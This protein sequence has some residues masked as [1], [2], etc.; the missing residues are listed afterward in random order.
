MATLLLAG[1]AGDDRPVDAGGDLADIAGKRWTVSLVEPIEPG[2]PAWPSTGADL[3]IDA[4]SRRAAGTTGCNRWTAGLDTD[5]PGTLRLQGIAS[6][7]MYCAEP[8]GI[9]ERERELLTALAAVGS[10]RLSGGNLVLEGDGGTSIRLER[11]SPADA[12]RVAEA[13]GGEP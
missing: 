10:Y 5:G 4:A 12:P 7:F 3:L 13:S 9:M 8:H 2:G 11:G 6:T 1:C